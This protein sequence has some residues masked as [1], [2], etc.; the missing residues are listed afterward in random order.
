MRAAQSDQQF[1]LALNEGDA[2]LKA[3]KLDVAQSAYSDAARLRTDDARARAGLDNVAD[4]RRRLQ[5]ARDQ[6]GGLDLERQERWSEAVA[7]V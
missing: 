7:L 6:Q 3:G 2:A 1:A 4:A 5:D